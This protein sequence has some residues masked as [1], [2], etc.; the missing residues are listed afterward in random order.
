MPT[1]LN[2]K[3]VAAT[4]LRSTVVCTA[5][6]K[7]KVPNLQGI[8][9]ACSGHMTAVVRLIGLE[10]ERPVWK[11]KLLSVLYFLWKCPALYTNGVCVRTYW[12]K[13]KKQ[14]Y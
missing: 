2:K 10:K 6:D 5:A 13:N 11:H 8:L 1:H 12:R 7:S 4:P 14:V 9:S 3:K